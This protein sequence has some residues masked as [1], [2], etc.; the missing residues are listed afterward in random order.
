MT[1]TSRFDNA[2]IKLYKA[3]H[4]G[5]LNPDDCKNCAVGNM[6]ENSDHWKHFTDKHGSIQLNYV[7]LVHQN[8]GRRFQGYTPLELLQIEASFLRGCGYTGLNKGPLLR[9]ENC[10]DKTTLFN[11]LSAVV[12]TL[13]RL[14]NIPNMMNCTRLFDFKAAG[15]TTPARVG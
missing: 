6:L 1:T 10:R 13:C 15:L 9:P 2:I 12:D 11:G 14:D 5:T 4:A 7:G 8:L 3:F